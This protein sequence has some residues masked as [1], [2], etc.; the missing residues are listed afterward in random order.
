MAWL[1]QGR[2]QGHGQRRIL[3][4]LAPP[5]LLE[6]R[7]QRQPFESL[8]TSASPLRASDPAPALQEPWNQR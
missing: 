3:V 7:D 5:A 4:L 8:G 2:E 6:P 1:K